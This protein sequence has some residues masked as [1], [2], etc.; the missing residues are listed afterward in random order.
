ML[1]ILIYFAL[2]ASFVHF[3][4]RPK[5]KTMTYGKLMEYVVFLIFWILTL[6]MMFAWTISSILT[7]LWMTVKDHYRPES[8]FGWIINIKNKVTRFLNKPI[9]SQKE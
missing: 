8:K 2:G 1:W 7:A 6:A 3:I 5:Y 9:F 4:F